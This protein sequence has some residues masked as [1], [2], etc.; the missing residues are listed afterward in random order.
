MKTKMNSGFI[1]LVCLFVYQVSF[2]QNSNLL[3]VSGN[4]LLFSDA[5]IHPELVL[6]FYQLNGGLL[7]WTTG[8]ESYRLRRESL[9]KQI[10][11]CIYLG[12]MPSGYHH[13][14]IN[15]VIA[16]ENIYT[17]STNA[18]AADRIFT[19]AAIALCK[20]IFEGKNTGSLVS[21][22]EI[23]KKYAAEKNNFLLSR[24]VQ[25]K[26]GNELAGFIISLEPQSGEYLLLKE[27]LRM[28]LNKKA[29]TS[30]RQLSVNLNLYRWI[31][32]FK[33]SNCIVVNIPSASLKYYQ[34]D[35][36]ALHMKVVVGKPSTKTPRFAAYCNQVVLYP[37]WNVPPSIALNEL[38]PKVKR[39]PSVLEA[40]NMQ[41][42]DGA[43]NVMVPAKINWRRYSRYY[44][45]YRFR[46][47]TGCDNSLGVIKFNIT[48]PYSVY[49][50]DTNNK[51][52]FLSG[53]RF[54]SHGCV[55]LEKP[56]ELGNL[57]LNNKLDTSFLQSCYKQQL[58]VP[59]DL[60]NPVPVFVIYSLTDVDPA[61][62]IKYYKDV[63]SLLK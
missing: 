30:V 38:L 18:A 53:S 23:S 9:K 16:A 17:D 10:D 26:T 48:D 63:Y 12:L 44:F 37:Y 56:I 20:D 21:Y 4:R 15:A 62:R 59:V 46:Q 51:T 13:D 31:H 41:V 45:P 14:K 32:H 43:G 27:E 34:A 8:G 22:D 40:M 7:F 28:Q 58:P 36:V 60:I 54:Y 33:F 5:L 24:L 11:S 39:N 49:L 2:S 29:L 55:R 52:A 61:N 47:S 6:K 3:P 19:D 35:T 42:V 50:H 25:V 57:V 1:F